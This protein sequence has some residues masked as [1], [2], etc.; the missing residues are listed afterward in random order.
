[1][2]GC[3][4]AREGRERRLARRI[5]VIVVIIAFV[6][7]Q[8]CKVLLLLMLIQVSHAQLGQLVARIST[9]RCRV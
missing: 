5:K 8:R 6:Y 2:E 4:V 3:R 7:D 9:N 1:M